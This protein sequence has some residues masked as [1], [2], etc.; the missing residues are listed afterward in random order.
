M[1]LSLA[2]FRPLSKH[3][4]VEAVLKTSCVNSCQEIVDTLITR[5]IG[6]FEYADNDFDRHG[7]VESKSLLLP[8]S[9]YRENQANYCNLLILPV[10][11]LNGC[12]SRQTR[13][14]NNG[15]I[16]FI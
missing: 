9:L 4:H 14:F 15:E 12:T 10:L 16:H 2:K 6:Q 1:F 5:L 11:L 13:R 8:A 7:F 3:R